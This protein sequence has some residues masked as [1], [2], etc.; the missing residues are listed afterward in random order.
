VDRDF[1]SV[2][3]YPEDVNARA[4]RRYHPGE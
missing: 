3:F 2:A 1:K 4:Q